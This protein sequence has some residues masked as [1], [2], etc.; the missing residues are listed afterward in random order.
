M[1]AS[2]V[3]LLALASVLVAGLAV[4]TAD[5]AE[6]R[7]LKVALDG[8]YPPFSR[9]VDDG[10]PVGFDVE[11]AE[12]L[13]ARM[14]ADCEVAVVGWDALLTSLLARRVDLVVASVPI[15]EELRRRV[16]FSR[17][18]HHIAPRFV[19]R[20]DAA[21]TD[22]APQALKDRRVGVRAGTAH[23]KWLADTHPGAERVLFPTEAAAGAALLD[24][25]VDLVFGDTLALY[26]FLDGAPR[27]RCGFVGAEVSSPRQF[28]SGAGIVFRREDRDLGTAVE[29]ALAEIGR[30][31]TLDRLAG[32]WFPFAIR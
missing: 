3:R 6:R 21:P 1:R 5:A 2:L 10:R 13:C 26:E 30:D 31:G 28:G 22:F 32:R 11:V 24:G 18:Y 14:S 19:A 8:A 9:V 16:E 20:L 7:R 15:G 27:G 23:E 4:A 25:R 12:A 29:K 17:P